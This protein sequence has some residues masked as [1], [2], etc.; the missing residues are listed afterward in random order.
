MKRII[1]ML[2]ACLLILS[3]T[4][5]GKAEVPEQPSDKPITLKMAD[6][7]VKAT[8]PAGYFAD[9]SKPLQ[10]NQVARYSCQDNYT[11][12]VFMMPKN[13]K[14]A[15]AAAEVYAQEKGVKSFSTTVAGN[16]LSAYNYRETEENQVLLVANY[17]TEVQ[18]GYLMLSFRT[19][20][21]PAQLEA[22][23]A[24][25]ESMKIS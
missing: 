12:D 3:A 21:K 1:A 5:C 8:L 19:N 17:L 24:F 15:T 18:D 4:A 10:A 22:V 20:G 14:D 23:G 16:T 11:L 2:L 13:A 9:R 6:G 7:K 25:L